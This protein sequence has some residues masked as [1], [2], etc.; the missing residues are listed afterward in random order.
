MNDAIGVA[1]AYREAM[2]SG[3]PTT[4]NGVYLFRNGD[5]KSIWRGHNHAFPCGW[6]P[7]YPVIHAELDALLDK[8]FCAIGSTMYA[9]WA[10]CDHCA[11]CI[12]T[13][14]VERLVRCAAAMRRE[15]P[16]WDES[17]RRGDEILRSGGV[18][19]VEVEPDPDV[20]YPTLRFRG[21]EWHPIRGF[22]DQ[23][24]VAT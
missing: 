2:C 10:A 11:A 9:V 20:E 24:A 6:K 3:C 16:S 7:G 14:G 4:Q 21:R 19:I 12:V 18:E 8:D 15:H 23:E 13:A 1:R 22:L 17:I 5:A